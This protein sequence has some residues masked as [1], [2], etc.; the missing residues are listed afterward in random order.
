MMVIQGVM[1]ERDEAEVNSRAHTC[2][3]ST[4]HMGNSM[5]LWVGLTRGD[6]EIAPS[7]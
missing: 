3:Q 5:D 2:L 6:R 4:S 1:G 7:P